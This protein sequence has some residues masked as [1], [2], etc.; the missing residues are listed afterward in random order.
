MPE[1]FTVKWRHLYP[2]TI[3]LLK[4][5]LDDALGLSETRLHLIQEPPSHLNADLGYPLVRE[6]RRYGI[7][8]ETVLKKVTQELEEAK[9]IESLKLESGYLNI[10]FDQIEYT[11]LFAEEFMKEQP[12][13]PKN[14]L[15]KNLKIV[16]EHT[17]ANPVHPMHIG[18]G[19]NSCL[20]DTIARMLRRG[21]ASVQTRFYIDDVGRQTAI[22]VYGLL[23]LGNPDEWEYMVRDK[24]PD[25]WIG[26]VYA[27]TH[28]LIELEKIKKEISKTTDADEK[29]RL[30]EQQDELVSDA[31]RLRDI[32]S[33]L[34]DR[35]SQAIINEEDPEKE[36]SRIMLGYERGKEETRKAVRR[37]VTLSLNGFRKTLE[38]LGISID[39]WDWESDVVWNGLVD[40]LFKEA[41][42]KGIIGEYKGAQ[43]IDFSDLAQDPDVRRLLRI[44]EGLEIPPLILRRSDG[45][46]LYTTRDI[47]Y[48]IK[49]FE[50]TGADFVINVIGKEQTLPQA[51]VRLALYALGYKEYAERL[52]HYA[53]EM[54]RLPGKRMSGRKGEYLS[55][56]EV[57]DALVARAA[58]EVRDKGIVSEASEIERVSEIIG[59]GAL[60]YSLVSV[61]ASKPLTVSFDEIINF[62]KNTAPYI[63]Y[64]HAR[65]AG[66]LEKAGDTHLPRDYRYVAEDRQRYLLVRELSKYPYI[67]S[68]SLSY[69]EPENIV[70]Y[71]GKLATLFNKWY[72]RDPVITE[73]DEDRRAFKIF[74][75]KATKTIIR[76]ALGILGVE[77]PDKM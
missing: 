7:K 28:T 3:I 50:E 66:I 13:Y 32:D 51:Q 67:L 12:A 1:Y 14:L 40:R 46:T 34:F 43:S 61:S 21:G 57:I 72:Q 77:A 25:H 42:S 18:H 11:R 26:L 48:S 5:A 71:L 75:V 35:L 39:Q 69:L 54:V 24:K 53:Y 33:S 36:V 19:R 47:A 55:L 10:Y 30:M 6:A 37:A 2:R 65:A 76:D 70:A 27:I 17:S 23:K 73:R 9:Y 15:E 64:T 8:P 38:R 62:E 59:A 4:N 74:I 63:Q 52:I 44:P 68:R 56:D 60:R 31:V 20:G 58:M 16:V 41:F 22:L 29:K 49:K 45:T